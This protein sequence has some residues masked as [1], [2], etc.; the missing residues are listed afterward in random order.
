MKFFYAIVIVVFMITGIFMLSNDKNKYDF[1]AT[2][3]GKSVN[4]KTFEGKY[5]AVYFGYLFCPDICPTTLALLGNGL[6]ELNRNDFEV[7]FISVDPE[8]DSNEA[9]TEM[10]KNFYEN[11]IGL[12][13]DDVAKVAKNYGAKYKKV[14]LKDSAIKYSIAHSS[15]I[16][17]LDKKG[18]Y[19]GEISNHTPENIKETLQNLI[20]D[21]P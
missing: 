3:N 1:H 9:L 4:L 20:K 10:A 12:V 11:S 14:E 19:Y 15:T 5:K 18:N 16:Y 17:L 21:R 8:R 6:D 2:V 7:I 13:V